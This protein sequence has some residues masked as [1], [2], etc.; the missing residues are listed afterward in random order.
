MTRQPDQLDI[1]LLSGDPGLPYQH[2]I[3]GRFSADDSAAAER[4]L[5]AVDGL[6]GYAARHLCDH[7]RMIDRLRQEPPDLVLNFCDTGYR[8]LQANEPNIPALL[9]LLEIPYTGAGA[10]AMHLCG[11]KALVRLVAASNGIPVP[12]ETLV[13]LHADPLV[14]P[15][16]YPAIIKPNGG[17]GSIGITR[18]AVVNDAIEAEAYLRWLADETD[19][20][21]ALIQ[22]FLTGPEYTIG[23]V[24]NPGQGFTVLPV[25]EID[26]SR[27]DPSLPPI[28]TYGSKVDPDSPYW[29]TLQFKPAEL[30]EET[31]ARLVEYGT[32]LF[33]RL[34]FR[35]Y[36]RIDFRAGADGVPR[37]LDPNFN[38]TWNDDGKMALMAGW[39]GHDYPDLLRLILEAARSRC[40]L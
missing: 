22:D 1:V 34:G 20:G 24:G 13:D 38:P 30:D 35:D 10:A 28:L 39:A 19:W 15:D 14:R 6:D 26:Y 25:L 3:D 32:W 21:Q 4:A 40:G 27:L 12:N 36:A 9:E 31:H 18:D 2:G 5:A 29:Q 33:E 8:N 16:L 7:E 37:L 23:L 11:D 17:C